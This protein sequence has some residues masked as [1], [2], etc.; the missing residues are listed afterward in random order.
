VDEI[1]AANGVSKKVT[2]LVY[3]HHH[4]LQNDVNRPGAAVCSV[5]T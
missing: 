3:S 1:A 2:H 5:R 4:A